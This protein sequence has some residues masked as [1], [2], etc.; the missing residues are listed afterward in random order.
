MSRFS[1]IL[2]T[3]RTIPIGPRVRTPGRPT[4]DHIR[5]AMSSSRTALDD[6]RRQVDEIDDAIH[7]LLMRRAKLGESIG[8][9]KGDGRATLRPEREAQILRR[10]ASRPEERPEGKECVRTV[11]HWWSPEH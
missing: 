4:G 10:L 2:T 5:A 7:D 9:V 11:S 3:S 1:L 8:L 6:L